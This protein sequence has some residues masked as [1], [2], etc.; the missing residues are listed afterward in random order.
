MKLFLLFIAA[1]PAMVFA[2]TKGFDKVKVKKAEDCKKGEPKVLEAANYVLSMPLHT[3]DEDYFEA[4]KLIIEWQTNTP[5]Y[6]FQIDASATDISSDKENEMLLGVYLACLT[7]FALENPDKAKDDLQMKVG[8]F[9]LLADYVAKAENKVKAT[10][11]IKNLLDA[12]EKGTMEEY[13]KG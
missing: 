2:Q 8:A 4:R 9:T 11:K 7:K 13:C 10:K 6:T 3:T 1:V 5:D 12:K